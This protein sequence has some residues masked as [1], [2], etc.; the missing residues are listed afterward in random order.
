MEDVMLDLETF[1]NDPNACI[2]QIGACYFD[3]Y[4]GEI[5][6]CFQRRVDARSSVA[7][8]G[9]IDADT[10]YWWLQQD[11][12]AVASITKNPKVHI[13]TAMAEL[14]EFLKPAKRIWSH[15]TFDFV[16]INEALKRLRLQQL[17]YKSA[18][19]IRT[20]MWLSGVQPADFKRIGVAHSAL[21]DATHQVEYCVAALKA[22]RK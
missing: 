7:T 15:A 4:T 10:V 17:Q 12:Q 22:L 19:D 18:R 14:L 21:D 9:I 6:T 13:A 1:G 8:G 3:Q 5:G 11:P 16:I 2:I 20:L